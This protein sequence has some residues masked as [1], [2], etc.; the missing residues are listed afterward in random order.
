MIFSN[1]LF[2]KT[3][4]D[5]PNVTRIPHLTTHA[6]TAMAVFSVTMQLSEGSEATYL[7]LDRGKDHCEA[8]SDTQNELW[9][10]AKLTFSDE[11]A[12]R[13]STLNKID[14][15]LTTLET[16]YGNREV[17]DNEYRIQLS[18]NVSKLAGALLLI[19]PTN[20]YPGAS[21]A[22]SAYKRIKG[23]KK[24]QFLPGFKVIGSH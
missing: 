6:L 13:C 17:D 2:N 18:S 21:R 12:L 23:D 4:S 19:S 14:I 20:Q 7:S 9:G 8:V 10:L 24:E 22:P 16:A 5:K 3:N 15:S 1:S 11:S